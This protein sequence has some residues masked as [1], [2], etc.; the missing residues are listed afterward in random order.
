[1]SFGEATEL[2]ESGVDYLET[3]DEEH[4]EQEDRFIAIGSIK[5]GVI[6]VAFTERDD[7]IVRLISARMA[8]NL[9]RER[10]EGHVRKK[11][12]R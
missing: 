2:F 12:E 3:F 11:N 8:T 5:R 1:M 4:S 9:E 7:D 6:V 10:L